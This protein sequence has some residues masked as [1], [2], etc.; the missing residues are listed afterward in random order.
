M[1]WGRPLVRAP[2]FVRWFRGSA[3]PTNHEVDREAA[4]PDRAGPWR[5]ADDTAAQRSPGASVADPADRAVRPPDPLLGNPQSQT[6]H[7]WHAA[8]DRRWRRRRW[9]RWRRWRRRRWWRRR[10]WW[11]RRRWRRRRWRRR[12][13]RS[14]RLR[15]VR[16]RRTGEATG[17]H[18]RVADV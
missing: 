18:E 4:P 8:A 13:A 15:R 7:A 11:R 17:S 9:R 14:H 2:P 6:E 12:A 10:W 1:K 16:R 3:S 5:L